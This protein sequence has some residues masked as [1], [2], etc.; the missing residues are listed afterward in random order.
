[1]LDGSRVYTIATYMYKKGRGAW[2]S[3]VDEKYYVCIQGNIFPFQPSP[4]F[5][6]IQLLVLNEAQL[7]SQFRSVQLYQPRLK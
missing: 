1:M 3:G 4:L 6:L 7:P 5:A 2:E